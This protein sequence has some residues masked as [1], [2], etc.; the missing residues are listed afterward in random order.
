VTLRPPDSRGESGG[1]S[2]GGV[3][4]SAVGDRQGAVARRRDVGAPIIKIA[5]WWT[6]LRHALHARST[7]CGVPVSRE[8]SPPWRLIGETAPTSF[9]RSPQALFRMRCVLRMGRTTVKRV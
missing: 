3:A 5:R 2:P 8:L 7:W 4:I 6:R 1:L 9:P